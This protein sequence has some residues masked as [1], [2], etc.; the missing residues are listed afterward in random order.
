MMTN[1]DFDANNAAYNDAADVAQDERHEQE[2]D[3]NSKRD[4]FPSGAVAV[5]NRYGRI[6]DHDT[7]VPV[8]TD[9]ETI[10]LDK[11]DVEPKAK[12]TGRKLLR[13]SGDDEA[14]HQIKA[15][16]AAARQLFDMS[17]LKKEK[18]KD[19]I[20]PANDNE[21]APNWLLLEAINRIKDLPERVRRK[22]TA[23]YLRELVDTAGSDA[24]GLSVHRPGG[25]PSVDHDVDRSS[26]GKVIFHN[27]QTLDR[28]WREYSQ[29]NGE[30]DAKRFDGS[31]RTSKRSAPV[32][33]G[34]NVVR[35]DLF[36]QRLF[37]AQTELE[38][39]AAVVGPLWLPLIDA[40]CN[41]AG[42]T[43]IAAQLGYSQSAVGSCIVMLALDVAA[44]HIEAYHA[45]TT[46][47]DFVESH[48]LPVAARRY[49]RAVAD[50]GTL[51]LAA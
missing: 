37:D 31:L 24:L 17:V 9:A 29:K 8:P 43:D 46:F 16:L 14:R 21:P 49:R 11:P 34:F 27:G 20:I 23:L 7:V 40:V 48:G 4:R 26:S 15:K 18:Q 38:D 50:D 35:D 33:G 36:V 32:G 44:K 19:S 1:I 13:L 25:A 41:N 6:I 42:F 12:D 39:I 10:D 45:A 5:Q 22:D 51:K 47:R 28:K 2:D 3:L 30:S